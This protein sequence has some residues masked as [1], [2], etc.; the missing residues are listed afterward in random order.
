MCW[1]PIKCAVGFCTLNMVILVID[2][3]GIGVRWIDMFS[4]QTLCKNEQK[5]SAFVS[6]FKH[7]FIH[8][9]LKHGK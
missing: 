5:S 3:K 6:V 1:A 9:F 2:F 4:L 8:L 7:R